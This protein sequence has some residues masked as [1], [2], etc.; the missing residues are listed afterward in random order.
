MAPENGDINCSLG[1]DGVA[2]IR[3]TCSFTCDDG[4]SLRGSPMRECQFRR[5][6]GTSWSGNEAR[7]VPGMC[8]MHAYLTTN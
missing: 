3:D 4:F 6:E 1:D 7:C 5:G 8:R 2:N